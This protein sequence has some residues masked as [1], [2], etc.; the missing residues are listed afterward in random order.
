M[1]VDLQIRAVQL[2]SDD[3]FLLEHLACQ[4]SSIEYG[5]LHDEALVLIGLVAIFPNIGEYGI[6]RL[7]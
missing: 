3:Q 2:D 7:S 6:S 4:G 1:T 5:A